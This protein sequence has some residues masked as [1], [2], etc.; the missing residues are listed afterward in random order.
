[1]NRAI[2]NGYFISDDWD[3][4]DWERVTRWLA[5]TYWSPGIGREEVERGAKNSSLVVGAYTADGKQAGYARIA[6]DKTRFA[7]FM[8]VFV[9]E[10]H[11]KKGLAQGMIRFIMEHPDHRDVYLWLLATHDAQDVY[12]KVGFGTLKHPDRW[13]VIN[14]GRPGGPPP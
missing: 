13:M 1:M 6:S 12:R 8:D 2:E 4:I 11:R 7:Y 3:R 14:Q 10:T 5:G 9:E